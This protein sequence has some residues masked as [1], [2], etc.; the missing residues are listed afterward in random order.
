[1]GSGTCKRTQRGFSMVEMLMAAFILAVG[2]LGLA[3]LQAMAL[4]ATRGGRNLGLAVKLAEHVMDAV[5]LEGRLTY[6]NS[7]LTDHTTSESL[8]SKNKSGYHL[9]YIDKSEVHKYYAI[10]SGTGGTVETEVDQAW[11]FHLCMTQDYQEGTKLSDVQVEV[12]FTDGVDASGQP[13]P[14]KARISR[15]VLHG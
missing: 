15:R 12:Q 1:M 3:M 14:R 11:L 2:L 10:D 7:N 6:L 13:I 5:E 4:R 9:A 8:N